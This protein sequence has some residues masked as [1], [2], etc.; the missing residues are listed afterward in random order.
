MMTIPSGQPERWQSDKEQRQMNIQGIMKMKIQS[1]TSSLLQ[2]GQ[3][4]QQ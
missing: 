3:N 1:P 2:K 4:T